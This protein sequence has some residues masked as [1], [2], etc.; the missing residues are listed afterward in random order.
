MLGNGTDRVSRLRIDRI[1]R[2]AA[3]I[4]LV[5]ALML[6]AGA[7]SETGKECASCHAAQARSQ[8]ATPMAN[9][10]ES[11]S[12]CDIL[13]TN[14]KLTWSD[15]QYSYQVVRDRDR[16]VYTVTDGKDSFTTPIHWAFGL[17]AAG[18]TYVYQWKGNWYEGHVSYYRKL[19]GLDVT[20]GARDI[21]PHNLEEAA[22]RQLSVK[23]TAE[24]FNCHATNALNAGHVEPEHLQAGVRCERCHGP[25]EKH[26]ASFQ[27]GNPE[28][29]AM[30]KL[31]KLQAEE[32]SDFC[33]QCHRTWAQIAAQGPHDINNVRFQPY[34][35][36][37][38]KCYDT[39]DRRI[40]CVACHDPHQEAV[41]TAG[42]Y[43]AKCLACHGDGKSDAARPAKI[44]PAASRD[45]VACHMPKYELP[46]SHNLFADHW[47][48][49]VKPGAPY[50]D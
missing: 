42:F 49:I 19:R 8:P 38:S 3:G 50:P 43:D 33:G 16:S 22:G 23:E 20:I 31:G 26:A 44:C 32:V 27:A 28:S 35:L 48:R 40:S 25:A 10:L 12:V 15:G 36:T 41:H 39:A 7:P 11:A 24:C 30:R 6:A 4:L 45:C 34:R 2:F 9:A 47:I 1:V 5:P 46:G 17:G 29:A 21:V 18:Q 13:Q 14:P 37:N